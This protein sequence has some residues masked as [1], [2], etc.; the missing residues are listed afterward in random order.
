[1]GQLTLRISLEQK[2]TAA[3]V[4]LEGRVAGPWAAELGSFWE[5]TAPLLASKELSIDLRNVTYADAAGKQVLSAIHGQTG[6]K[7]VASTPLTQHLA[8]EITAGFKDVDKEFE[9]EASE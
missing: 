4:T 1:M 9:N 6:A 8:A 2:E 3:K 7:L 5:A